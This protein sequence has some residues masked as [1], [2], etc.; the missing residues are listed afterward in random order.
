MFLKNK[1]I[2]IISPQSWTGL[3]VSKH[4][5]ALTLAQRGNQVYFLDPPVIGK[6]QGREKVTIDP[7][8][9]HPRLLIIRNFISF[10]YV[11][12]FHLPFLFYLLIKP[13]IRNI[14]KAVGRPLDI[15]WSFDLSNVYPLS[16]FPE[17]AL[18]IFHPV[19]LPH[20]DAGILGAK[21]ADI[22]F[23]TSP[24]ILKHYSHRKIPAFFI[25]HGVANI[26]LQDQVVSRHDSV[27][28][29]GYSGN[30]LRHDIDRA[31]MLH[32]IRD[33]SSVIFEFWGTDRV[34]DEKANEK[35]DADTIRFIRDLK[36][37]AN[38]I[39]HGPVSYERLPAALAR[40]DGFLLCYDLSTK[41]RVGPNYHKLM[42]YFTTGK[43]IVSS[44]IE[45]Y[46]SQPELVKMVQELNNAN[47]PELFR[48]VISD[49]GQ[50]NSKELQ[51]KRKNYAQ[52]HTYDKQ[53]EKVEK[54][55]SKSFA[56]NT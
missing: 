48:S 43:V 56:I 50:H 52:A 3:W 33:N 4:H 31:C 32:I 40:M 1:V 8:G 10:P 27:I 37:Q 7:S 18:R 6:S 5:Y 34:P 24:E 35:E 23:S 38:V 19:D 16:F 11:F 21:K 54:L 46:A 17:S 49:L 29:I 42:E 45:L 41:N 14:L 44:Y 28:R 15:V 39:L 30:L 20:T 12:K 53:L 9:V 26:F 2:L 51:K 55:L 25:D 47:L 13:Q 36:S 22:I